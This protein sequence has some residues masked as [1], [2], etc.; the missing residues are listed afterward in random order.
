VLLTSDQRVYVALPDEARQQLQ[1]RATELGMS[2]SG[3]IRYL[4]LNWLSKRKTAT[5]G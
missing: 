2:V 5:D 1:E 4:I 3:L